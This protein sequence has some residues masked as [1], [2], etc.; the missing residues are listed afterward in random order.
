M[1]T[2]YREYMNRLQ[3]PPEAARVLLPLADHRMEELG[4]QYLSGRLTW[5]EAL[6]A[7]GP[8]F[9][10]QMMLIFVCFPGVI[11]RYEEEGIPEEV[12]WNSM[13]D[14]RCR[15]EECQ[16]IQ[17]EWGTSDAAW[18]AG[19]LELKRFGLGRLQFEKTFFILD[20]PWQCSGLTIHPRDPVVAI[21]IP[22]AGPLTEDLCLD[23]YRRAYDFFPEQRIGDHLVLVCNSWLLDPEYRTFLPP[24]S[25]ILRFQQDFE[26]LSLEKRDAFKDAWRVFGTEAERPLEELPRK[27]SVQRGFADFLTSGGK[28]GKGYGAFLWGRDGRIV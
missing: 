23:A 13:M 11:R 22:S 16:R 3:F 18:Y 25:N 21:H 5:K 10:R 28:T 2:D 15:L 1:Q 12:F 7:A 24:D 27:T 26:I 17:G 9:G 20:Q 19:F 4:R 14:L 6:E 8:D